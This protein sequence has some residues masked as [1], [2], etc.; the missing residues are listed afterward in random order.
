MLPFFNYI[1]THHLLSTNIK[2]LWLT[3]HLNIIESKYILYPILFQVMYEDMCHKVV[4][5]II[6][7]LEYAYCMRRAKYCLLTDLPF[8]ILY[9]MTSH[10]YTK[11]QNIY[12]YHILECKGKLMFYEIICKEQSNCEIY[13]INHVYFIKLSKLSE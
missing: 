7:N 9:D 8:E 12:D 4:Y 10:N 13:N 2:K 11:H 3:H 1:K 5:H 6:N